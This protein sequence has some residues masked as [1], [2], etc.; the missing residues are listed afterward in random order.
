MEF[1]PKLATECSLCHKTR[2]GIEFET[3]GNYYS[4]TKVTICTYC[5]VEINN[6]LLVPTTRRQKDKAKA[7]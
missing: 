3:K 4:H 6:A 7:K 5:L 2:R 1:I